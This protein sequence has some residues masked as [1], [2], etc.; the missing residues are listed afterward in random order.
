MCLGEALG[1]GPRIVWLDGLGHYTALAALPNALKTAVDFFAQDLPPDAIVPPPSSPAPSPRQTLVNFLHQCLAFISVEPQVGHC[2]LADLDLCVIQQD[3]KKIEGRLY[4]ARG[5]RPQFRVQAKL[6]GLPDLAFGWGQL[7]WMASEK[8][9]Y[10]GV[11]P[12]EAKAVDPVGFANQRYLK[13]LGVIAGVLAAVAS[14]Q[15][16]SIRGSPWRQ[17]RNRAVGR[18]FA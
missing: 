3:G 14:A 2:H 17:V 15:R 12:H 4:L 6:S 10:Q 1:I 18:R 9:V 13:Q 8:I 7:P 5:P 16:S 11:L